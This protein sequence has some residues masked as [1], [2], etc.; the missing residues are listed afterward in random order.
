[1]SELLSAARRG[2]EKT[3]RK[4]NAE[5]ARIGTPLPGSQPYDNLRP[6]N[7]PLRFDQHTAIEFLC[8]LHPHMGDE[9][10]RNEFKLGRIT[11]KQAPIRKDQV[12]RSGWRIEHLIPGTV[13][14]AVNAGIK[15]VYED[16][17]L[18]VVDKPAPLP[19]HACGRFNRNS[20]VYI[21]SQVYQG[22]RL[23]MSHRLD[24]NTTGLVIICRKRVAADA[25][26][27]EFEHGRVKKTYLAKVHGHPD[28]N[29]FSCSAPISGEP[30]IAGVRLV[31]ESGLNAVT[32]FKM[33]KRL[34]D[35]DSIVECQPKT[36]RT[37]QIRAHS[38]HLG[39]PIVGDP[40]YRLD[41]QVVE[42]QTLS[43]DSPPM[44]LHAWKLRFRHPVTKE[45]LLLEAAAPDWTRAASF[46]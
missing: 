12:V 7:V 36:G 4:A 1:M 3:N 46:A 18:L 45:T 39:H 13:E 22:E 40:S 30:S 32:D 20:L 27:D 24:A 9:F 23:R 35:G 34:L 42:S 28:G 38:W 29:D 2:N 37:N 41:G 10:W 14:P 16:E 31:D 21:L 26:R 5:I 15:L 43:V 6:V 25:I 33:L 8:G 11:Y 19:M 17:C 44:C